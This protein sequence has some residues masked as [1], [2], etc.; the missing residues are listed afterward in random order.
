MV[1]GRTTNKLKDGTKRVLEYYVCGAWK[2]K[3][4][5]VCRSNSV[6]TEYAD[7]FVLN[8]L[9]TLMKSD[10]FIKE[11]VKSVNQCNEKMFA[12]LQKEYDIYAKQLKELE[13][14]M[15]KTFDAYTEEL[16]PKAMY[17]EKAKMLE[18]QIL[19]LNEL[20]EPLSNQIQGST[21]KDISYET[22]K[23]VLMN[24]LNAFQNALTREQRKRLLHLII[25]KITIGEDRKIDSIQL[26]LNDEMLKELKLEVDD[27]SVDES[28]TSFSILIAI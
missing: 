18:E 9:Q 22:I 7:S 23:E 10:Q 24:F 8:K 16:I 28:F 3:G 17:I 26:K 21:V 14:K 27:L 15:A 20:M 2:N 5:L 11:L 25:H 13:Q 4:T 19:A 12:P 1:I 6:R